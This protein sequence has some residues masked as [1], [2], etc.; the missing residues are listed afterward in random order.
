MLGANLANNLPAYLALEPTADSPARLGALLVGV[1]A[2]PLISPWAS[3]ATL[4]WHA[5]LRAVGV[6]VPWRRFVLLGV[7]AAPLIV[8]LS[9][10]PL[11]LL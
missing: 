9:V 1:D 4:L 11:V 5:R 10:I 2:G 6:E 8:A 3:L 7:V